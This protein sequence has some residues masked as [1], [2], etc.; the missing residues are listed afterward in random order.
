MGQPPV[1]RAPRSV[2]LGRGCDVG[3]RAAR[4]SPHRQP[5]LDRTNISAGWWR[6]MSKALVSA[7][8]SRGAR[9]ERVSHHGV[10]AD[11]PRSMRRAVLRTWRGCGAGQR[12][13][14]SSP[15]RRPRRDRT[16][17]VTGH[18]QGGA[19]VF[20]STAELY[21][22]RLAHVSLYGVAADGLRSTRYTAR[23]WHGCVVSQRA[24]RFVP[25]PSVGARPL[26]HRDQTAVGGSKGIDQRVQIPWRASRARIAAWSRGRRSTEHAPCSADLAWLG[27]GQTRGALHPHTAG[28]SSTASKPRQVSSTS[29]E[30]SWA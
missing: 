9:S 14:R 1:E 17:T 8:K 27:G 22:A 28:R 10:A 2:D 6:Q 3:Q 15:R 18:R 30:E 16:N 23:T 19:K 20:T 13:A 12:E 26:Q 4:S 24:A 7:L 11:G 29:F 5:R 21:G 25:T